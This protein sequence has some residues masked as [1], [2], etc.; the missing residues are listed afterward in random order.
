MRSFGIVSIVGILI[1]FT[2]IYC[3]TPNQTSSSEQKPIQN[4]NFEIKEVYFKETDNPNEVLLVITG[5]AGSEGFYKY[6]IHFPPQTSAP[7]G[8]GPIEVG[9][10]K[11]CREERCKP[12]NPCQQFFTKDLVARSYPDNVPEFGKSYSAEITFYLNDGSLEKWEGRVDW[13]N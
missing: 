1:A 9:E 5:I 11:P 3:A 12:L 8:I 6:V 7:Q 10:E 13:K 2:L 4:C